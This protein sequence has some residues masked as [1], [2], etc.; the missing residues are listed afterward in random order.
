[1]AYE[2]LLESDIVE[3]QRAIEEQIM[4]EN[5]RRIEEQ[6]AIQESMAASEQTEQTRVSADGQNNP[7]SEPQQPAKTDDS[8]AS[9]DLNP[10]ITENRGDGDERKVE[11]AECESNP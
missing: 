6:V 11:G 4:L 2:E 9:P 7:Q 5:M 1:M 10:P 3:Q 8:P